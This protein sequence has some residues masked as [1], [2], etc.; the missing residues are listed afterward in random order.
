MQLSQP[1]Q[2]LLMTL[3]KDVNRSIQRSRSRHV[4]DVQMNEDPKDETDC[5]DHDAGGSLSPALDPDPELQFEERLSKALA[6][7]DNLKTQ[8]ASLQHQLEDL[9]GR[10]DRLQDSNVR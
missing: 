2:L 4:D 10:F 8:T 5:V 1:T 3:I 9:E 6:E 7:N